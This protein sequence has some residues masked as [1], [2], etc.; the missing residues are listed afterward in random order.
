VYVHRGPDFCPEG[1][2][3]RGS[4]LTGQLFVLQWP[5]D[6]MPWMPEKKC[7]VQESRASLEQ[8]TFISYCVR[9]PLIFPLPLCIPDRLLRSR[10]MTSL[11]RQEGLKILIVRYSCFTHFAQS[12]R[13]GHRYREAFRCNFICPYHEQIATIQPGHWHDAR[14]PKTAPNVFCRFRPDCKVRR[15]PLQGSLV[16]SLKGILS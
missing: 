2:V 12:V 9:T 1:Y 4:L 16:A 14:V 13:C 7:V 11:P 15:W 8:V 3:P 5:E 10:T 6:R